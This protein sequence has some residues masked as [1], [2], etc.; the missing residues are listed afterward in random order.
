MFA[1]IL[2]AV[3]GS[4]P[5]LSAAR[6]GIALA[7]R[8]GSRVTIVTVTTPWA[9]LF[10]RE[11]AVVVPAAIVPENEYELRTKTAATAI[12]NSVADNAQ[13]AGVDHK[14][15]HC[16]HRDAYEAIIETAARERCDLIVIGSQ[17]RRGIAGMLL[18][19]EATKVVSHSTLPVLVCRAA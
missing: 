13:Y 9:T 4:A 14:T 12:L 16:R 6:R 18:G 15:V 2:L 11:P 5:S 19:S 17:G 8:L 10:A 7:S 1:N 3:D